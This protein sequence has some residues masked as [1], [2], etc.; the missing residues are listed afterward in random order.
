MGDH[1]AFM[2]HTMHVQD[3]MSQIRLSS[4]TILSIESQHLDD[5]LN[6][7]DTINLIIETFAD[8]KAHNKSF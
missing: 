4:L 3:S 6:F 2:H 5:V 7:I 1:D 8:N